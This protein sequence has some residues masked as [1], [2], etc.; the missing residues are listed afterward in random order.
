MKK[1]RDKITRS[2]TTSIEA[3]KPF[4]QFAKSHPEITKISLGII[5]PIKTSPSRRIKTTPEPA[6]LLIHIRGVRAI[7]TIRFFTPNPSLLKKD[8]ESFA[9][10]LGFEIS[11]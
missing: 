1:S 3:V 10:M 6:C 4:L 5:K 7:Q 11:K 9:N 2:H 8:V